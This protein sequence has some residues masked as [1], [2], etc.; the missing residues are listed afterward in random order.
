MKRT[1]DDMNQQ[2]NPNQGSAF[3]ALVASPFYFVARKMKQTARQALELYQNPTEFLHQAI[4]HNNTLGVIAAI[5][6]GAHL[7]AV[8]L[9]LQNAVRNGQTDIARHLIQKGGIDVNDYDYSEIIGE[10]PYS[11]SGTVLTMACNFGH[12][13]MVRMLILDCQARARGSDLGRAI[14]RKDSQM[15]RVLVQEGKVNVE[16]VDTLFMSGLQLAAGWNCLEIAQILI[17]IGKAD[18]NAQCR[19]CLTPLH[20]AAANNHTEMGR[21]LLQ[22]QAKV[23]AIELYGYAPLHSAAEN[24]SAAF[25]R[26]LI[27]EFHADVEVRTR[28]GHTPLTLALAH[29]KIDVARVLI[30]H[31]ADVNAIDRD[32]RTVLANVAQAGRINAINFLLDIE[33]VRNHPSVG[34]SLAYSQNAA[35]LRAAE[36]GDLL[37]INRL[38]AYPEVMEQ[39]TA[40]DNAAL[41]AAQTF[42]RLAVIERL[43]QIPAVRNFR[44]AEAPELRHIANNRESAM[45][46]LDADQLGML[47]TVKKHYQNKFLEMN[48]T[49]AILE[50]Y[51]QYLRAQYLAHPALDANGNSLPIEFDPKVDPRPLYGNIYHCAL[52]FLSSPNPWISDSA[53]WVEVLE[54]GFAAK[55]SPEAKI[56]LAY[57]WLAASDESFTPVGNFPTHESIKKH[58]T[59]EVGFHI[60]RAHNWDKTR[61]NEKTQK[62]EEFHNLEEADKPSCALGM[63]QRTA[64][65]VPGN[66]ITQMPHARDFNAIIFA[67]RFAEQLIASSEKNTENLSVKLNNLDLGTLSQLKLTLEKYVWHAGNIE[68]LSPDEKH[69]MQHLTVNGNLV[70]LFIQE[71]SSWFGADRIENPKKKINWQ[72]KEYPSYEAFAQALAL[73]A[74]FCFYDKIRFIIDG[75]IKE[76]TPKVQAVIPVLPSTAELISL[77]ATTTTGI[78]TLTPVMTASMQMPMPVVTTVCDA[79][80]ADEGNEEQARKR[81]RH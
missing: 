56:N 79:S 21:L 54:N 30:E 33:A 19:N 10:S 40:N 59:E 17:E 62:E 29:N 44:G 24:N 61:L 45:R 63:D 47:A 64:Q 50:N 73:N 69:L 41:R 38:L 70:N 42:S 3:F 20:R 81:R 43:M 78:P 27:N 12:V 49:D 58:F 13:D 5:Y 60:G 67:N 74:G 34:A 23:N 66:P 76:K 46:A 32:G 1:H 25:V 16:H 57:M 53:E 35:L 18:V 15:V 52:R 8:K 48:G 2:P 4:G 80:A 28:A 71:A 7:D 68:E 37:T 77:P 36:Y 26:M 51:R 31:N 75:L 14:I 6:A 22:H 55:I 65:S 39:V 72:G 11:T 9:G